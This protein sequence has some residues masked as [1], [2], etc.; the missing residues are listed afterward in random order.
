MDGPLL[1][2]VSPDELAPQC[3]ARDRLGAV[4]ASHAD[5]RSKEG[6]TGHNQR[7]CTPRTNAQT[8][9]AS[10]PAHPRTLAGRSWEHR[11]KAAV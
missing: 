11:R 10:P 8:N 2:D 9:V 5:Q 6:L 4:R 3:S 1:A 7:G